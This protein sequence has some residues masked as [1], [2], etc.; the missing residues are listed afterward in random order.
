MQGWKLRG[1]FSREKRIRFSSL[2]QACSKK[3]KS[4]DIISWKNYTTPDG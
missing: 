2:D 3:K 1:R 4:E